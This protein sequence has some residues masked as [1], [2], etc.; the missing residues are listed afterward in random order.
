[1]SRLI[2]IFPNA[3]FEPRF[4]PV[5]PAPSPRTSPALQSPFCTLKESSVPTALATDKPQQ[6]VHALKN[7]LTLV[8]EKIPAVRSVAMTFL[9][10]AGAA[11][12]PENATGSATVLSDWILRG[13]GNRNSHELTNYLDGLGIQRSA[14]ADNVFLRFSASL[15]GKNLLA[16]LPVY[17][18]IVQRPHLPDDGFEPSAD[19]ALQQL[20]A[21]EDE[22]AHKLSLL[23][24]QRHLPFPFGRPSCGNREDLEA[25]TPDQL[26]QDAKQRISPKNTILSI[27][28]NFNWPDLVASVEKNFAG[29]A[30]TN[31]PALA[32]SPAP[33][34]TFHLTQETNQSQI[35]LAYDT[36]PDNHPDSILIHTAISV[37]SGGMGARLF[38][39]IREK[40]GLCYSVNAGYASL[41]NLGSVFGY[42]GTSPDRAQKTLDSFLVELK[43]LQEGIT[44]DEFD[45]AI[46][47]MKSRTIMQGD[48]SAARAGS[49][50]Y[51]FY[52][53]GRTRTLEEMRDLIESVTLAKVNNFLAAN[54]IKNITVVTLGPTP[55]NVNL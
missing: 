32:E 41:K 24:R 48:S 29:W 42:S 23:L 33:R 19:L 30:P 21:I 44:Q 18:D 26:R 54:P 39:E 35:G 47:G 46:I 28:G 2:G 14:S 45:R 3:L 40:Q 49:L 11:S 52:H 1:V 25:L 4:A 51:D 16:V 20:D 36:L 37:L 6:H 38:T 53:R 8:A 55:L 15:L 17:A 27:A 9:V 43:R 7:G 50:A 22:P 10:P 31:P 13:A 12:D 5:L 34:G